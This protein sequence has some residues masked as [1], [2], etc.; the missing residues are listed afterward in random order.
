M[1]VDPFD[2]VIVG[3]DGNSPAQGRVHLPGEDGLTKC[4][5]NFA[6][7]PGFVPAIMVNLEDDFCRHCDPTVQ[8]RSGESARTLVEH[9]VG[10]EAADRLM[11]ESP[12]VVTDGGRD[13]PDGGWEDTGS[14]A[15]LRRF[16]RAEATLDDAHNALAALQVGEVGDNRLNDLTELLSTLNEWSN[17]TG[18]RADQAATEVGEDGGDA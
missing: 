8:S 4:S 9:I 1:N 13:V 14:E 18:S 16:E 10:E 5:C 17:W 15:S 12:E 2:L 11:D 7:V 6:R 3:R